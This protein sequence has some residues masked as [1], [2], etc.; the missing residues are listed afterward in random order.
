MSPMRFHNT[1][2]IR[3]SGHSVLTTSDR[4][5]SCAGM[6]WGELWG[7]KKAPRSSGGDSLKNESSDNH[8]G[9]EVA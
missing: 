1:S 7:G 6:S 4:S 8:R 3:P 2:S 9:R 5:G